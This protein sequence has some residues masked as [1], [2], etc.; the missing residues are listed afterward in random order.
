LYQHRK[1]DLPGLGSFT[2]DPSVVLPAEPDRSGHLV[3]SG[4]VFRNTQVNEPDDQLIGYIKEQTGKMKSLAAADLDFFLTTGKQLLNIGKPFYL[5]GIGTLTKNRE[6]KLDFTPGEYHIALPEEGG[7]ER[8]P[9]QEKRK[10][11]FDEPVH[12][13]ENRGTTGRQ[14]LLLI[15]I[16]AGLVAIGWGG[17]HLYKKN[18][19]IEAPPE[20]QPV[21]IKQPAA[22]AGDS[23]AP[24]NSPAA[25]RDSPPATQAVTNP[26]SASASTPAS[27]PASNPATNPATTSATT[28]STTGA[29]SS[30]DNVDTRLYRF[31]ILQTYNKGHA[32]RRYNQLLG[33]QLNIK[34]DQKDSSFFKL[35]FPISAAVKDT[36]HIKDSLVDVY[37]AHVSIE[38]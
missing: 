8:K 25:R 35:Y 34:M 37:A 3:A 11:S 33:Y 20:N 12:E 16:I 9:R 38:N 5:D 4:I 15:G 14:A 24:G 21:V 29:P 23:A 27:T 32:L 10:Q 6:G 19:Y 26:P 17:Y 28:S 36:S 31:V 2:L 22:G 30:T 1:L 7:V 18:N 13:V